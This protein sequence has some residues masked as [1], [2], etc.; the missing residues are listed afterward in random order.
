[1][2]RTV[3]IHDPRDIH[4][5]VPRDDSPTNLL[6]ETPLI[7]ESAGRVPMT[8]IVTHPEYTRGKIT[9]IIIRALPP[10]GANKQTHQ[11]PYTRYFNI[12]LFFDSQL[13]IFCIV[14]LVCI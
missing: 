2:I 14:D 7:G 3:R 9:L 8:N 11:S 13:I 10:R 1:M 6:L 12:F 5:Q 4:I